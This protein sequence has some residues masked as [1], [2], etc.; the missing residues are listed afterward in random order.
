MFTKVLRVSKLTHNLKESLNNL[1]LFPHNFFHCQ[2]S[3]RMEV[4][5]PFWIMLILHIETC[6]YYTRIYFGSIEY[7][8]E[9]RHYSGNTLTKL[10]IQ[11]YI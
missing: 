2:I 10:N 7:R 3:M 6:Y 11:N 1:K 9:R 4:F 5:K 8:L